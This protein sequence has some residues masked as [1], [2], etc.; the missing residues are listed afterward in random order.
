MISYYH[1]G[2]KEIQYVFLYTEILKTSLK[3]VYLKV[4]AI[5]F[6]EL[7]ILSFSLV[8]VCVCPILGNSK[9]HD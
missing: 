4:N 7:F 1:S 9:C 8:C 5:H 6:N 2:F 3:I